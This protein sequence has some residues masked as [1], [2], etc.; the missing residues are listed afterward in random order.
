MSETQGRIGNTSSDYRH[1]Q[2][3]LAALPR[4][5]FQLLLLA[6]NDLCRGPDLVGAL[7]LLPAARAL[8]LPF[9]VRP[10]PLLAG[11]FSPRP[12]DRLGNFLATAYLPFLG[13]L[14]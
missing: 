6:Q 12:T 1:P 2:R 3:R 10:A 11:S 4:S 13:S 7:R 5:P 9:S 14:G 8:R